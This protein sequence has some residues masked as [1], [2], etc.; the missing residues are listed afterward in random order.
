VDTGW[1]VFKALRVL[2]DLV[3]IETRQLL[4]T[5]QVLT[6]IDQSSSDSSVEPHLVHF[7]K[8]V[9]HHGDFG[10]FKGPDGLGKTLL[11]VLIEEAF[12]LEADLCKAIVKRRDI[13][14]VH[15]LVASLEFLLESDLHLLVEQACL[16]V[17]P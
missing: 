12:A 10:P 5:Q 4:L 3:G 7:I 15:H 8:L 9:K 1:L 2:K 6:V 16:N 14:R 11:D 13:D 17:G